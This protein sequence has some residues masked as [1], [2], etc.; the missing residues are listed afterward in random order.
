V[1]LEAVK[2]AQFKNHQSRSFVFRPGLNGLAGRN[3]TGKTNILEAIYLLCMGRHNGHLTD[4]Q[5][6]HHSGAFFRLEGSFVRLDARESVVLKYASGQRKVLE[7]NGATVERLSHHIGRFPVVMIAPDDVALV[8]EG[9]EDRR[10]FVDS[11]LSQ[12][13]PAYLEALIKYQTA[14]RQRNALLKSGHDGRHIDEG[15]LSVLDQLLLGPALQIYQKRKDYAG[16]IRPLFAGFYGTLSDN[17]ETADLQYVS[18]LDSGDMATLLQ[19]NREKDRALGRTSRGVHKDDLLL[20]LDDQMAKKFGSQGQLKSFLLALRLAQYEELHQ[21]LGI[22]PLLLLDDV[23]DKLDQTRVENL[24]R[25]ISGP[26]YGQVF[27]T[28]THPDRL[29]ETLLHG[30]ADDAFTLECLSG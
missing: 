18:D 15:V 4:R 1:Y 16:R 14:L 24:V 10:R 19:Q 27:M 21:D 13:D 28:D 3:G 29:R 11:A 12:T 30:G 20:L 9:G 23:F 17:R 2:L 25:L 8:Q 5:L 7:R 6:V 26:G 22:K